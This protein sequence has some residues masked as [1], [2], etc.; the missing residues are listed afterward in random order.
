MSTS[1]I[2]PHLAEPQ[3][4]YATAEDSEAYLTAVARG[5]HSDYAADHWE[6]E[7]K[8]IEWDRSFGFTVEGRWIATCGAFGRTMTVPGGEVP[9]AAVTIVTVAPS[10]RRR[11]LLNQMMRHQL[12]DIQQKGA[13]PVALLWASESLIYGRY[14][15]G[16]ATPQLQI[17]G[18]TRS[19]AFRPSVDLGQGSTDE[20]TQGEY[21]TAASTL[22]EALLV[23]RPGSLNRTADWW[24]VNLYDPEDWRKGA[25]AL[26]FVLHF[27]AS[28]Q[29]DGYASFR[30]RDSDDERLPGRQVVVGEVDAT[31][32]DA[33]AG[34]WRYLMDLDL[35]RSFRQHTA[36][37]DE[38]LRYLVDDQ[39]AIK[40]E[41]TDGTYA[42][43]V[44]LP[45]ALEARGYSSDVD[46]VIEVRDALLPVNHGRF[47]L[48]TGSDAA[49]VT[50]STSSPDLSLDTRELGAGYLG[51]TSLEALHR[52]GLVEEHRPGAVAALASALHGPTAPFCPDFF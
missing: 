42:R 17:S 9:V 4:V 43:L 2:P 18:L 23:H 16:H 34:V 51:G 8:L 50:R 7:A 44:D 13:E 30:V 29:V 3:L 33:Y 5:F 11:G 27:G 15:Y 39:R 14:G 21:V 45:T 32:P 26:R 28:G 1:R 6:L 46:V 49:V 31:T 22:R 36:P 19:T 38:P 41:I 40:S 37:M 24:N 20:V 48:Q 52:A 12:E 35:V 47:R 25:S 10:Y